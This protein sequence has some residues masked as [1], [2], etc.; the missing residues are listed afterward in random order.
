MNIATIIGGYALAALLALPAACSAT[1]PPPPAPIEH[2]VH[3]GD[4]VDISPPDIL[5][6]RWD[7]ADAYDEAYR[8]YRDVYYALKPVFAAG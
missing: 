3:D 8:R 2:I 6:I 1:T 4:H 5:T 7:G